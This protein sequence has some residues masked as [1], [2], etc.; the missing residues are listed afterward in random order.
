MI[1]TV[2]AIFSIAA[3]A[4]CAS[5]VGMTRGAAD[6]TDIALDDLSPETARQFMDAVAIES[7][8]RIDPVFSPDGEQIAFTYRDTIRV[9]STSDGTPVA[10][11][12]GDE[13]AE[14]AGVSLAD[15]DI[16]IQQEPFQALLKFKGGALA[17][18]LVAGAEPVAASPREVPRMVRAMFPMNGYD[19]RE[20]LSPDGRVFASLDGPDL[21]IRHVG[22]D[23]VRVLTAETNPARKWFHGNDIWEASGTIWAS[24]SSTFIARL[25]D[26]TQTPGIDIIDYLGDGDEHSVFA[27]W[28]RAGEPLP[29]TELYAVNAQTGALT[30]LSPPGTI[31]DHLFFIEWSPSNDAILAIQYARDLSRQDIFVIDIQTGAARTLVTRTEE[32]GWVKWPSGPQTIRHIPAGGYL[33]R[34]DEDGFFQYY[35]LS[36]SGET[37][38]QLTQGEVDVGEVIGFSPDGEW[39]YYTS[40]VSPQR[41]YDRIPHRVS[42]DGGAPQELSD[43]AG[44]HD[45]TLSPDGRYLVSVHSD[46]NR[47]SRTDLLSADGTFIATLAQTTLPETLNGLPLPEPFTVMAAD[48]ETMMHGTLMKPRGFDPARSY[49]VIHRVYG[50]MQSRVQRSG[51]WPEGLGYPGA[52]YSLMLNYL[53]DAGYIVVTIDAPGSPGRGRAYNLAQQENWP[54]TTPDDYAAGLLELARSRPWMDTERIG[55]DGNS[56]GGYVALYSALERP[57]IYKTISISVPEIDLRD[58]VQWIEWQ[59]GTPQDNPDIYANGNLANRIDELESDIMIVAGMSDVNVPISNTMKLLD[60]LAEAGKPYDLVIFPGTNHAHQG[61]GDRYAYAVERIRTFHDAHLKPE[62]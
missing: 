28:A 49:P 13:L 45:A 37:I 41:P 33:L 53:A 48:G 26:A 19:R 59:I 38:A 8:G 4:A 12:T 42:L 1:R 16:E 22:R 27:Y 62:D 39:L 30:R 15:I 52:E 47:A 54:G 7:T 14:I 5:P 31:N 25:H 17:L 24:D 2:C 61:R 9:V 6:R 60:G 44:V 21:A 55:I 46:R 23:E 50:A 57:D 58:H 51:F 20:N 3:M 35:R 10:R 56:W 18:P 36:E 43:Q 32:Q 34:S 29:R 40:P 11:W